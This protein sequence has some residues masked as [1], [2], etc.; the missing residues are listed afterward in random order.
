MSALRMLICKVESN[1]R[2]VDTVM[3]RDAKHPQEQCRRIFDDLAKNASLSF[4]I[5][6]NNQGEHFGKCD[7]NTSSYISCVEGFIMRM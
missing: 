2:M 6:V 7:F 1:A 4:Y 3:E 5:E